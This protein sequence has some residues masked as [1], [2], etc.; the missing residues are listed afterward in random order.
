MVA[1]TLLYGSENSSKKNTNASKI[2]EV[3]IKCIFISKMEGWTTT[4]K[5]VTPSEQN[6]K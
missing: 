4:E 1:A 5:M 2:Q 3:D 6:G